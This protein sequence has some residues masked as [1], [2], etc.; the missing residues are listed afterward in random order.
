MTTT[1]TTTTHAQTV[2]RL[3]EIVAGSLPAT[4]EDTARVVAAL[5][6]IRVRD[7]FLWDLAQYDA[8]IYPA[9][10]DVYAAGAYL[11]SAWNG[12]EDRTDPTVAPLATIVGLL[13]WIVGADDL[14]AHAIAR[15]LEA[16]PRYSLANLAAATMAAGLPVAMWRDSLADLSRNECLGAA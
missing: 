5:S 12:L 16:D 14:A 4:P 10:A 3:H 7:T 11:S 9:D 6:S 15:A 8:G 13:A 1:T 2:E